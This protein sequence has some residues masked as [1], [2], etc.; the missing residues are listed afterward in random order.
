LKVNL[1]SSSFTRNIRKAAYFFLIPSLIYYVTVWVYPLFRNIQISFLKYNFIDAPKFVMFDNY[2]NLFKDK[3]FWNALKNTFAYTGIV[4]P[5]LLI[6]AF[7]VALL[8]N[9]IARGRRFF[10][11]IIFITTSFSMVA[12]A[13]IFR[14]M[15]VT[16]FGVINMWLVNI[17]GMQPVGWLTDSRIALYTVAITGIWKELGW[18]MMIYL[19]AIQNVDVTL[20]EAAK[21]DGANA[22]QIIKNVTIPQLKPVILLT[23]IVAIILELQVFAQ[24]YIMTG[25]GPSRSTETIVYY[26]YKAAFRSFDAGYASAMSLILFII[27]FIIT[28]IQLRVFRTEN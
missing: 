5:I 6:S 18:F 22:V 13:I 26:I 11:T 10:S 19:A 7:L 2:I 9:E 27:I 12:V 17:F 23:T 3:Y 15:F 14:L 25:G 8:L 4:V 28:V 24:S 16:E 20:I 1:K 21:I